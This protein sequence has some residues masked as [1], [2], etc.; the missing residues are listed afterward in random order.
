MR[1]DLRQVNLLQADLS[2]VRHFAIESGR[3]LM[4]GDADD[5]EWDRSS[6]GDDEEDDYGDDLEEEPTRDCPYCGFEMLEVCIQCPSC[7]QYLS[8][9]DSY[10][11]RHPLW[12]VAA[13]V[14]CLVAVLFWLIV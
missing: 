5:D 11:R 1:V 7:G 3:I 10:E 2:Q 12:I 14:L 8:Q 6:Y 13:A 4:R 9:E